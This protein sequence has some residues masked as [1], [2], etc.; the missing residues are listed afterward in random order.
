MSESNEKQEKFFGTYFDWDVVLRLSRWAGIAA[1][2]VLSAYLFNWLIAVAQLLIQLASGVFFDKGMNFLNVL[3]I[4]TPY[5]LMP[6]PGFVYFI[7]LQSV[8][9][10]LLILM[11]M[12][13][14][15]RR[16]ARIK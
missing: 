3:N 5:V 12:E 9:K 1:W 2:V 13:D 14:N 7:G 10:A 4:F 8:G 16:T 15:L 11:D 6:L